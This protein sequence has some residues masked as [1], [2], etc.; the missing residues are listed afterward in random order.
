MVCRLVLFAVFVA[1]LGALA[2]AVIGTQGYF[3]VQ[4]DG[5]T[6]IYLVA[7]GIPWSFAL[8]PLAFFEAAIPLL[9]LAVVVL[10]LVNLWLLWGRCQR[11][12]K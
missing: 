3:G 8:M 6:A 5:L 11:R 10:P 1:Y 12:G 2:L 7:L 4:P 9:Q